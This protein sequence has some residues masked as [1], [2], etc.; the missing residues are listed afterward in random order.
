M[1]EYTV[2]EGDL[3]GAGVKSSRARNLAKKIN[4]LNPRVRKRYAD[5]VKSFSQKYGGDGYEIDIHPQSGGLRTAAY[6]RSL[7]KT[8]KGPV[9]SPTSSWHTVGGAT[10]FQIYHNGKLDPGTTGKNPYVTK[11]APIAKQFALHAPIR[12]DVGHFQAV[13]FTAGRRGA[14]VEQF[15]SDG[16]A[17]TPPGDLVPLGNRVLKYT[18][19][20]PKM[21]GEDIRNLQNT[22]IAAGYDVGKFGAD[23][24]YGA[25][26]R[27]AVKEFQADAVAR[28]AQIA[29]DGKV[30]DKTRTLFL[31]AMA[32]QAPSQLPGRLSDEFVRPE[33]T[34]IFKRYVEGLDAPKVAP[35][36]RPSPESILS[37]MASAAAA[38]SGIMRP[39]PG[40]SGSEMAKESPLGIL[41]GVSTRPPVRA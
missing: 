31:E 4:E 3:T 18:P 25:D 40:L 36:A 39:D 6:Q 19:G 29:V 28:G 23:G 32:Q 21:Q 1:A 5:T 7:K 10:D 30:G 15:I 24:V 8:V 37:R 22:L 34:N 27:D 26:T 17:P 11:L 13:E 20:L 41:S 2:S 14:P 12:N 16:N 33:P 38:R 35:S 9:G